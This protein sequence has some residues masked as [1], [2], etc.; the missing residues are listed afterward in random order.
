[1]G[2]GKNRN[3][4]CPCGSGKKSKR[5][6]HN[7]FMNH[8]E[9]KVKDTYGNDFKKH[10]KFNTHNG[11]SKI[12][13]DYKVPKGYLDDFGLL[14]KRE[15][16]EE[17]SI[18]YCGSYQPTFP[19]MGMVM[20]GFSFPFSMSENPDDYINTTFVN[21]GT[22]MVK[23]NQITTSFNYFIGNQTNWRTQ[24]IEKGENVVDVESLTSELTYTLVFD[25]YG[26]DM[27]EF[28][29]K[30]KSDESFYIKVKVD[31]D[32]LENTFLGKTEYYCELLF[33]EFEDRSE[34][35]EKFYEKSYGQMVV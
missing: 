5:C 17:H 34:Q 9:D 33:K 27:T 31:S 19:D 21:K 22:E 18:C 23:Q 26:Q 16:I 3:K 28:V 25:K 4:H 35:H 32:I 7:D 1:M 14:L 8:I 30:F 12:P 2:K 11:L 15:G 20:S 6:F 13:K 24:K 29:K 10:Y